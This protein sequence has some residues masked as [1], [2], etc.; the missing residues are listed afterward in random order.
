MVTFFISVI[1]FILIFS[2]LILV[3]EFGHFWMAKRAGVRVEE[4]GFGLPPRIFGK[5]K[6]STLYSLNWIPFGGFVRLYGEDP[7]EKGAIKSKESFITKTPWQ[8]TTI[9]LGG[10]FMNFVLAW[11]LITFGLLFGLEPLIIGY[12]QFADQVRNGN[13]SMSP[14]HVFEK[15]NAEIEVRTGDYLMMIN[16]FP[17]NKV[18]DIE[19]YIATL[20]GKEL[21]LWIRHFGDDDGEI[22]GYDPGIGSIDRKYTLSRSAAKEALQLFPVASVPRVIMQ[23]DTQLLGLQKG[24]T[25]LRINQK[26]VLG[27]QDFFDYL[28][29]GKV[30]K[31]DVLRDG[32]IMTVSPNT[33]FSHTIVDQVLEDSPAS[34]AGIMSGDV[35]VSIEG[36][37]VFEPREVQDVTKASAVN[38]D[39]LN[40][41]FLREGKEI[42]IDVIP[43]ADGLIGVALSPMKTT[44]G[45]DIEFY[46]SFFISSVIDVKAEKYGI[47]KAPFKAF[48][49]I[50]NVSLITAKMMGEVFS[51]ILSS[52][53]VPDSV[54]GPVGI[55]Q[56]THISVQDGFFAVI[57]FAAIL[58]LSLGVL[59][60]LPFPALDGGRFVFV[61][62]EGI[63]GRRISHKFE[64]MVHAIGFVFLLLLIVL[65][66]WNDITKLF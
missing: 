4:F 11:L 56:M 38:S 15:A 5:K 8:K 54:A 20:P 12:D 19:S 3:H 6:G 50:K 9:V 55:A 28:Y 7:S 24:D 36:T 10:V 47:F 51:R 23:K 64:A 66:T 42:S 63:S 44:G 26:E 30:G 18:T 37:E 33:S 59:N 58:S 61:I 31:I 1:V 21:E 62:F 52:G 45:L 13:V 25:V 22:N 48:S 40:Y 46:E 39:S 29:K 27:E 17:L 41:V 60:V 2:V 65:I 35:F 53:E 43:N 32:R 34:L 14:Y 49:E 57:R 16:D